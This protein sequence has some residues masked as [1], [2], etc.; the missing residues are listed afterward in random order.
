MP[1]K[2]SRIPDS[3]STIRICA[4]FLFGRWLLVV[5][6]QVHCP[7]QR[8]RMANDKRLTTN[9]CLAC[10]RSANRFS[11]YRQLDDKAAADWLVFFHSDRTMMVLHNS[12]HNRQ[13]QPRAALLGR[14]VGQEQPLFNLARNSL[15]GVGDH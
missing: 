6:T 4:M 1:R 2:D 10:R 12:V 5:S 3:S 13:T 14:E 15:P 7:P 8:N 9:D 11:R